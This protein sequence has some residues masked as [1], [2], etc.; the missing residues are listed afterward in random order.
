MINRILGI[1]PKEEVKETKGD[2]NKIFSADSPDRPVDRDKPDVQIGPDGQ[3]VPLRRGI[4]DG[5]EAPVTPALPESP[6]QEFPHESPDHPGDP[7]YLD[8]L[9]VGTDEDG[10]VIQTVKTILDLPKY[11][12]WKKKT[13]RFQEEKL[14]NLHRLNFWTGVPYEDLMDIA[15]DLLFENTQKKFLKPIPGA[16]K[17]KRSFLTKDEGER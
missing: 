11:K 14:E 10:Q 7:E 4:P 12:T 5:P 8:D 13:Y 17:K 6:D 1:E 2:D 15:L 16:R 9:T 3:S